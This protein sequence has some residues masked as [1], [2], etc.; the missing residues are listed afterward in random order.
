M[1]GHEWAIDAEKAL[2][3]GQLSVRCEDFLLE[4]DLGL[5]HTSFYFYLLDIVLLL[6]GRYSRPNSYPYL[7]YSNHTEQD[8]SSADIKLSVPAGLKQ[9]RNP[10]IIASPRKIQAVMTEPLS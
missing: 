1:F 7:L 4:N 5:R 2:V 3:R 6:Q 10:I 9:L 8:Q